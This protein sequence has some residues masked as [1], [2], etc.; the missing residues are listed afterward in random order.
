MVPSI[1]RNPVS[2]YDSTRSEPATPLAIQQPE[3]KSIPDQ[4]G[5]PIEPKP[6]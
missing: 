6:D 3:I 1:H 5:I 2:S 4:P